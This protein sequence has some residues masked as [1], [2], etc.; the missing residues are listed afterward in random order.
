MD[1]FTNNNLI[2]SDITGDGNIDCIIG[3]TIPN[4]TEVDNLMEA[5]REGK[6]T[7]DDIDDKFVIFSSQGSGAIIWSIFPST[8]EGYTQLKDE[9][10]RMKNIHHAFSIPVSFLKNE[11]EN[12]N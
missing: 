6:I 11:L 9:R 12:T 4:H 5:V 3:A 1:I 7:Q 2:I 8:D 10:K